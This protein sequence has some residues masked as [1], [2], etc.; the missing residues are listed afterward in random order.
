MRAARTRRRRGFV[1]R[2]TWRGRAARARLRELRSVRRLRGARRALPHAGQRAG[3]GLV[4]R[5]AMPESLRRFRH[6]RQ[7]MTFEHSM[8]RTATLC[9]LAFGAV[10]VYSASSGTTLL[11][12]G[13]DSSE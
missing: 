6:E 9:L 7:A 4:K 5:L 2:A 11:S 1:S 3:A 12:Q 10:M 8:L 13:G